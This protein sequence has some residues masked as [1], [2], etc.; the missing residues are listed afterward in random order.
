ML[1]EKILWST[2]DVGWRGFGGWSFGR[3][4]HYSR[5][6]K[7]CGVSQQKSPMSHGV[8]SPATG[9]EQSP[10]IHRPYMGT[11]T[12]PYTGPVLLQNNSY[13]A[14]RTKNPKTARAI[15]FW[16]EPQTQRN[17]GRTGQFNHCG[18]FTGPL[19]L[20]DL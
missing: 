17:D 11:S 18:F 13:R 16:A 8:G 7:N 15:V 4:E 10:Y 19:Y 5:S 14:S 1:I 2:Y 3:K 6:P 9:A 12:M 20:D